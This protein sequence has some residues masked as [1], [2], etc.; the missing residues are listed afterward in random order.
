MS[1][2]I[3]SL[4]ILGKLYFKIPLYLESPLIIGCGADENSDVDVL[5]EL[6]SSRP[7]IPATSL[8]GVFRRYLETMAAENAISGLPETCAAPEEMIASLFGE[9]NTA[10]SQSVLQCKDIILDEKEYVIRT[11]DGVKISAESQTG[12]DGKKY[13]YEIIEGKILRRGEKNAPF[14]LDL[15]ITLRPKHDP[16]CFKKLITIII[17]ALDS[18]DIRLGAKTNKGFGRLRVIKNEVHWRHLDFTSLDQVWEWLTGEINYQELTG[19]NADLLPKQSDEFSIEAQFH[20]KNAMLI[21]SYPVG[22]D[23]ADAVHIT[24]SQWPGRSCSRNDL[25]GKDL[26]DAVHITQ[27]GRPVLPGTSLM[28]AIRHRARKI[29]QIRLQNPERV[30]DMMR[31]LFGDVLTDSSADQPS[32]K[33]EKAWR[34]RVRIDERLIELDPVSEIQTRIKVDRFTGGTIDGA[35]LQELPLWKT[36]VTAP[37]SIRISVLDKCKDEEAFLL[38]LVLKDLWSSDLPIGGTKNIGRG[39]LSG[40]SADIRWRGR[41]YHLTSEAGGIKADAEFTALA[42]EFE[43]G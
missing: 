42:K 14:F 31:D 23:L 39:F 20:I 37:V 32:N 43:K 3:Y 35:L 36:T 25:V 9:R 40:E 27:S 17:L 34:G 1:K 22:K 5:R 26:A 28:G 38:L 19:L 6:P 2:E 18:G 29:L 21:R 15:E 16:E 41:N 4:P 13:N 30:N 11:R 8:I 33:R 10:G 24:R 7:V 12:E